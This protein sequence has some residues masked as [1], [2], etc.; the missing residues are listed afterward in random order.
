MASVET[1]PDLQ[2]APRLIFLVTEDWYFWAHRLPQA[3]AART[4]F[5]GARKWGREDSNL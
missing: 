3:R 1:R 2:A 4:F 5:L